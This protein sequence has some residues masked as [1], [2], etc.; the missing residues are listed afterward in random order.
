MF[1][2]GCEHIIQDNEI[3]VSKTDLK[4]RITYANT[5]F[6]KFS[7]YSK[8]QVMGA[9]HNIVRHPHMPKYV[10]KL[11]W[12]TLAEKKE[13]FAYILNRSANGDHYWVFAHVTP[14]RDSADRIVGYHS[15]RRSINRKVVDTV[16]AP[17]Y[18]GLLRA[19]QR[20]SNPNE[21][22]AASAKMMADTLTGMG[23]SYDEFIFSL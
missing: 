21:G 23:K 10:F 5:T 13:V 15:N 18:D 14:S 4:G 7:G 12:D 20:H 8:R 9:P 11:L 2:T 3:L 22:M 1:L 6:L 17:L 16:I 19:E